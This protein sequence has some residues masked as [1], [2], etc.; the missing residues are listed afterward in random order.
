MTSK[1]HGITQSYQKD[2]CKSNE[3]RSVGEEQRPGEITNE[4]VLNIAFWT[5]FGF[6]L[7]EAVF[8][9]IANS[10]AMLEDAEAMSVDAL[11]YL[12]NLCAERIKHRPDNERERQLPSAVREYERELRRLYLEVIPPLISVT[13]LVIVT[14]YA[15]KDALVS[16]RLP[17]DVPEEDVNVNI[18][19]WFSGANLLLDFVNVTCFARAHQAFGLTTVKREAAPTRYSIRGGETHHLIRNDAVGDEVEHD[20]S[21]GLGAGEQLLVNLNMCSGKYLFESQVV[22][23]RFMIIS[24]TYSQICNISSSLCSMDG[25]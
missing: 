3:V 8:A 4:Y 25:M 20:D 21:E 18:M 11:T 2:I 19:M 1:T 13:T 22:C 5:F 9:L 10:Q 12:F 17:D 14:A 16:L 7:L 15:V 24:T 23:K 6:M